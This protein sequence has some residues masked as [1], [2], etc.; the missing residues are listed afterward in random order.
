LVL[1]HPWD[2]R[3][4]WARFPPAAGRYDIAIGGRKLAGLSQH[5]P[6]DGSIIAGASVLM[7]GDPHELATA[8]NC[9][10]VRLAAVDAAILRRSQ[11]LQET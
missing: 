9:F 1:S 5:W 6:A 8:V 4:K 3:A 11:V 7:G 10:H 2:L